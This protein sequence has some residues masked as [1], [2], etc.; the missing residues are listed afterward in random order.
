MWD[1]ILKVFH[2]F[3]DTIL[4][5]GERRVRVSPVPD[6]DDT[7]TPVRKE[8]QAAKQRDAVVPRRADE[9]TTLP[10]GLG[11]TAR[12]WRLLKYEIGGLALFWEEAQYFY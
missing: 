11:P 6:S 10:P 12:T 7:G 5:Q 9:E 2:T 3:K 8:T 1:T 4:T